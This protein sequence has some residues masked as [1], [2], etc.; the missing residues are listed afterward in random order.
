YK[1][2]AVAYLNEDSS[3]KILNSFYNIGDNKIKIIDSISF[4]ITDMLTFS[5]IVGKWTD[6]EFD[7]IIFIA[8]HYYYN[9]FI[10]VLEQYN[11]KKPVLVV[12]QPDIALSQSNKNQNTSDAVFFHTCNFDNK[13]DELEAFETKFNNKYGHFPGHIAI[14]AYDSMRLLAEAYRGAATAEPL[15]AAQEIRK[16]INYKGLCG[17]YNFNDS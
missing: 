4:N 17:T 9:M 5:H 12:S 1:S 10:P 2:A 11:M 7:A 8:P 13:T 16:I 6:L 3:I 14:D 15:K